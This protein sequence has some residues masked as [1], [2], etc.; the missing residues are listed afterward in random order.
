[1]GIIIFLILCMLFFAGLTWFFTAT[2][3]STSAFLCLI[4]A[5]LISLALITVVCFY[6]K[7]SY[8]VNMYNLIKGSNIPV[9]S[10]FYLG[11]V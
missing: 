5:L 7:A 11:G 1:M 3:A 2:E 10:W 4:T 6:I 8:G 9:D